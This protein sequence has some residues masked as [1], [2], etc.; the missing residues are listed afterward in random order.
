[1]MKPRH[2]KLLEELPKNNYKVYPSAIKAGYSPITADK[3]PKQILRTALKA[4]ANEALEMIE[5]NSPA[6]SK[7]LKAT[8]ADIIGMNREQVFERLRYIATQE[9]DLSTALKVLAPLSKDLGVNISDEQA[10]ITIPVLNI[11]VR[12]S[13]EA[14]SEDITT[15]HGSI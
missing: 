4:Q 8:L 6:S 11:G 12:E 14:P 3:N 15:N 9:R 10:N 13:I 5:P 7:E 1:M 2:K